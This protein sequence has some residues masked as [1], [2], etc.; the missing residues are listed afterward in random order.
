MQAR[1][2]GAL[3]YVARASG[4]D[5]DARRDHPFHPGTAD[6][7]PVLRTDGDVLA[8][9]LVRAGEVEASVALLRALLRG[10]KPGTVVG[11]PKRRRPMERSS[12]VGLVECWRG[13]IA[14][15]VEIRDGVV[16]RLKI[17]DPSFMTWPAL[18]VALNGTIVADFPVTN[19]SFNLSYAGND[20]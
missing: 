16:A 8:R 13:T 2:I 7:V 6:V 11:E 1:E 18:P 4:V 12:G 10:A 20:L 9:F 14:H 15:R 3:G 5:V 17:V 19:K